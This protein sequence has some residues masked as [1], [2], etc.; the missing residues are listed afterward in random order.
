MSKQSKDGC[1]EFPFARAKYNK[2]SNERVDVLPTTPTLASATLS[3]IETVSLRYLKEELSNVPHDKKSSL[4]HAQRTTDLVNDDHL[5]R[6]LH[7]ENFD[8]DVSVY[9]FNMI[10]CRQIFSN[11]PFNFQNVQLALKR[12]LRYW[13]NRHKVFGDNYALPMTLNG[14]CTIFSILYM[15]CANIIV[16]YFVLQ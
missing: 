13:T 2:R 16:L 14:M 10:L 4:V 11:N 15:M 6:F 7:V 5:L 9:G 1:A 3:N 12:L 8:V